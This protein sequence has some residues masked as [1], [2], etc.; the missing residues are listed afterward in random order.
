MEVSTYFSKKFFGTNQGKKSILT[1]CLYTI[2]RQLLCESET[3]GMLM[4]PF[5]S[6]DM[7]FLKNSAPVDVVGCLIK[8]DLNFLKQYYI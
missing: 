8:G 7:K 6:S 4:G 3:F 1:N 5:V 2:T